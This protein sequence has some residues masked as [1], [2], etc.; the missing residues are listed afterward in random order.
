MVDGLEAEQSHIQV[1][2]YVSYSK[3]LHCFGQA[4]AEQMFKSGAQIIN[5]GPELGICYNIKNCTEPLCPPLAS[6]TGNG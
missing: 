1:M 3:S 5:W 4:E 2:E 6:H